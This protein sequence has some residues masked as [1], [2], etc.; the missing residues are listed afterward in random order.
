MNRST[1]CEIKYM[2]RLD[3]IKGQVYDWGWFQ[4][5]DSYTRTKITPITLHKHTITED[6]KGVYKF[7]EQ[8]LNRSTFCEIKYLKSL[9]FNSKGW[10]SDWGLFLKY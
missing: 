1:F 5:T 9:G 8:Y 4:N 7:K 3:F 10:V 2:N 6:M